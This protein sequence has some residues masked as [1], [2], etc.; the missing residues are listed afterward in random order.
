[1]DK[2]L[3]KK[4]TDL[5]KKAMKAEFDSATDFWFLSPYDR[6][7]FITSKEETVAPR[8]HCTCMV[9]IKLGPQKYAYVALYDKDTGKKPNVYLRSGFPRFVVEEQI[10][11]T[12]SRRRIRLS[13]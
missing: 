10:R 4:W 12:V 9:L 3:V 7:P 5:L 13:Y 8:K 2:T 6:G 1:M 11:R